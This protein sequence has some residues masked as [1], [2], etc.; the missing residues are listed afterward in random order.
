[1]KFAIG[2]TLAL[3]AVSAEKK[4][5]WSW[6]WCGWSYPETEVQNFNQ[7]DFTGNWYEIQRD[8]ML[9]PWECVTQD[10]T[11]NPDDTYYP[12]RLDNYINANKVI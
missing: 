6:G 11:I 4:F 2:A 1:M 5:N 10:V 3:Q 12:L 9:K 8:N 7:Q